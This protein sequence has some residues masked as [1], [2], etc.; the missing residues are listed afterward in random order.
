MPQTETALLEVGFWHKPQHSRHVYKIP[1]LKN[2]HTHTLLQ[3]NFIMKM[4]V[5]T[6]TTAGYVISSISRE[7]QMK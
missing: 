6:G 7:H 3:L 1:T 4:K 2:T 5:T